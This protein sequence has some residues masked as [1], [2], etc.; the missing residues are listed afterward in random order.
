MSFH[1]DELI[2]QRCFTLHGGVTGT[3]RSFC[4]SSDVQVICSFPR[5][6][7]FVMLGDAQSLEAVDR[8]EHKG[9]DAYGQRETC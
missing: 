9:G 3:N 1:K 7:V 6:A 2:L 4:N 5:H 8:D